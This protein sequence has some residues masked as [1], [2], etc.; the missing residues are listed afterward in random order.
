MWFAYFHF[1]H[2][3]EVG[4]LL[5][6]SYCSIVIL[7][8][9]NFVAQDILEKTWL[10]TLMVFPKPWIKPLL[11]L[12]WFFSF[13]H[14]FIDSKNKTRWQLI[15]SANIKYKLCKRQ[16]YLYDRYHLISKTKIYANQTKRPVNTNR[17]SYKIGNIKKLM[18]QLITAPG[19][20]L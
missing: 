1:S 17:V 7:Q 19:T 10:K 12:S 2:S 13:L 14:Q 8:N 18:I 9:F 3:Y 6:T 15:E 5:K 16:N 11:E 20:V 4:R